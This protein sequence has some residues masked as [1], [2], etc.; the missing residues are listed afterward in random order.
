MLESAPSW[1][2][3]LPTLLDVTR[4]RTVIAYNAPFDAGVIARHT[5]ATGRLLEHLAEAGQWACLMERRAAWDGSGQGTRLGAA[6]RAL[7]DCRAAL[8]LLE[9][10]AAGPA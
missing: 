5:R 10:I 7:G 9:L 1:S 2:E 8:E 3:V 6:H 4:F